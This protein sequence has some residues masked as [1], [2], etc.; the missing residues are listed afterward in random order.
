MSKKVSTFDFVMQNNILSKAK[1]KEF[2]SLSLK[3]E[4][5]RSG[6]FIVEG[7]KGVI[8]TLGVF[9]VE[10]L[11]STKEWADRNPEIL[12]KWADRFLIA[13]RRGIE[14]I[15]SL[16]SL[17]EIIAVYRKPSE[18]PVALDSN[19]LYLLLDVIQDPGNLGT[20]IRTCDWFG[21]YDIFASKN[22]VD[23]YSPK[24]VQSTMGS[25]S[26]VKVHYTDLKELIL[27]HP[28]FPVIGTLL[29]GNPV[30]EMK[31]SSKGFLLM[32]NEGRGISDELKKLITL[33]VTIPPVNSESHPDSLNVAIATAILLNDIKLN[34]IG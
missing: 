21:V 5:D 12:T 2:K 11:I 24:T 8:D 18:T 28:K 23:V 3:K 10:C 32:G 19:K 14:I 1:A 15:S 17:P 29:E 6:M 20:I 26:R 9:D 25:L 4:R 27:A 30:N 22:T 13:D 34:K 31:I 16:N 33:P 7:E